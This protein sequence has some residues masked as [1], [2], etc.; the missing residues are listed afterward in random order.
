M[1]YRLWSVKKAP[2]QLRA[3][4]DAGGIDRGPVEIA[5]ES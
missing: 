2:T 4:G 3:G 1:K 5:K